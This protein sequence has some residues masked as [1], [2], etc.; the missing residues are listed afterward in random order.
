LWHWPIAALFTGHGPTPSLWVRFGLV[1]LSFALAA[2]S[3]RFVEQPFRQKPY[4]TETRRVLVRAA[5]AMAGVAVL[6]IGVPR[7]GAALKPKSALADQVLNYRRNNPA[8]TRNG[9]C[10]LDS[11][12]KD[13]SR[14]RP[15]ICLAL[16]SDRRNLLVMGD[17]HAAH[18][19]PAFAEVRPD[20][21]VLQATASG[22]PPLR[23]GD[24][25]PRCR[26]LYEFVFEEYLPKHR[27]DTIVLASHW[28][29]S[30]SRELQKT[31]LHLRKHARRVVVFG[32]VAEYDDDV[33]RLLARSIIE[34]DPALPG[35][36]LRR[37]VHRRDRQLARIMRDAE[38]EYFSVY[39]ATC[40]GKK[41][42]L[43]VAPGIPMQND[44]HHLSLPGAKLVLQR[45]GPTLFR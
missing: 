17:S 14:F 30:V 32:P 12:Y 28:P 21:N 6:A 35:R 25:P 15:E 5:A 22:C 33:P 19:T 23:R 31:V 11:G 40:P 9:T 29:G 36:H 2:L 20:I 16:A 3:Y 18:F 45:L 10:F 4:R 41:C 13:F 26:Q 39:E 44:Q 7:A 38:I 37:G 42:T 43:W 24:G 27:V 1:A 8:K 34:D